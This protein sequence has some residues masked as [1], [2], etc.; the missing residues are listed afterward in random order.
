VNSS[1]ISKGVLIDESVPIDEAFKSRK[2]YKIIVDRS[3]HVEGG[4]NMRIEFLYHHDPSLTGVKNNT[5]DTSIIA[6]GVIDETKLI[7]TGFVDFPEDR[8]YNFWYHPDEGTIYWDADKGNYSWESREDEDEDEDEDENKGFDIKATT[9]V[10]TSDEI[11]EPT[12][13]GTCMSAKGINHATSDKAEIELSD[14]SSGQS[15]RYE[16]KTYG[17]DGSRA[18]QNIGIMIC[19]AKERCQEGDGRYVYTRGGKSGRFV[20]NGTSVYATVLPYGDESDEGSAYGGNWTMKLCPGTPPPT[21]TTPITVVPSWDVKNCHADIE[22]SGNVLQLDASSSR[23][24]DD[25]FCYAIPKEKPVISNGSYEISVDFRHMNSQSGANSG[26]VGLMFN[27]VNDKNFDFVDVR[28]NSPDR[29]Q[30]GYVKENKLMI[31][32]SLKHSGVLIGKHNIKILV[33]KAKYTRVLLDDDEMGTFTAHYNT[34][35]SG[36]VMSCNGY[37]NLVNFVNFKLIPSN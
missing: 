33:N 17:R 26:D 1:F 7:D 21:T 37:S 31:K 9:E 23:W 36:G 18:Y 2:D 34:K 4:W 12:T 14:L 20:A 30:I 11:T 32:H 19:E 24:P 22:S 10:A 3:I 25:L 13:E 35:N 15:V 29:F 5:G 16:F 27:M 6:N 8:K 28:I